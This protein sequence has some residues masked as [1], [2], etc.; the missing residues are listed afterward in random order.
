MSRGVGLTELLTELPTAV[1]VLFAVL[2]QLGDF[3]FVSTASLLSYWL[4]SATPRLG[5]G[6]TRERGAVL[7]G[8]V[9]TAATVSIALKAVF[10]FPRPPNPEIVAAAAELP[11]PVEPFYES[12]VTG[13]GYGF[14]SGH[15]T[16]TVLVWGGFA[17]ALRV[18]TRRQRYAVAAAVVAVVS[19]SR[20]V[21]G[22]HYLVDVVAGAA[23]AGAVLWLAV[24]RLRTPTRVFAFVTLVAVVGLIA[25]GS[26]RD[27]AAVLGMGIGGLVASTALDSVREPT[28][29]GGAVTATLGA[30]WLGTLAAAV[31]LVAPPEPVVSALVAVGMGTALALPLLGERVAKKSGRGSGS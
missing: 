30:V 17:W 25:G 22:V 2:T 24:T 31:V 12:V 15:A 29:R 18:G 6:L 13:Q 21:L 8:L 9:A 3:W 16:T 1:V 26:S 19:L 14:P 28:R 4:A 7:V 10:A 27:T 23:I 11:W 5:R 20:L